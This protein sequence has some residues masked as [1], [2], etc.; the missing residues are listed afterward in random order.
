LNQWGGFSFL[1]AEEMSQVD[2]A[3][4]EGYGVD[5]LML[6]ENAGAAAA[7]LA[8]RLLGGVKGRSIV[9]LVGKGNNGG[10][11]LVA[12]RR[13][14]NWGADARVIL[15]CPKDE[16]RELSAKQLRII[17]RMGI[18]VAGPEQD[19]GE[20]DLV[21]DAL[22]GYN[23]RGDPRGPVAEMIRMAN[24]SGTPILAVD[25]PSGLDATSGTPGDP[26]IKAEATVTFGF[27]KTGFLGLAAK[28]L[29]GELY[30]ADIS[31]PWELYAKYSQ[32]AR[33]FSKDVLLRVF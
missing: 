17:E 13:L 19:L 30:L 6:M 14:E 4:M 5:V 7:E 15:G 3:A 28:R 27:P 20:A 22:L 18:P 2:K 23:S 21:I 24:S 1:T 26:C 32:K 10:D 29:V 12:V 9:C 11:G 25:V 8:A 16:M 33:V 31:L